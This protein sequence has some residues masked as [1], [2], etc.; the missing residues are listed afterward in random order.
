MGIIYSYNNIHCDDSENAP[1]GRIKTGEV[2]PN[3]E[4]AIE[5]EGCGKVHSSSHSTPHDQ[6][7]ITTL[8]QRIT[9]LKNHTTDL[10]NKLVPIY[11]ELKQ[12]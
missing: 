9:S 8:N 6:D 10:E 11:Q 4:P 2:D 3:S 12:L 1:L 7:P 5:S